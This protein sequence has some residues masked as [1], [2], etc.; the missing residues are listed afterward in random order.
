MI[1]S[2]DLEEKCIVQCTCIL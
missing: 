2:S 1:I